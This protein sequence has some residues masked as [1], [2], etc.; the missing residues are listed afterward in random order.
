[1]AGGIGSRFWPYSRNSRPKQFLD[2]FGTGKSLLQMTVDRFLPLIPEKNILVVTNAAYKALVLEQLPA[3]DESQ[4]LC[5][6]C[7]RNT[8]PCIAYATARIQSMLEKQGL[9]E[10]ANIVVAASDHLITDNTAFL[11]T[12]G[13]C[14]DYISDH[15]DIVTLGMLPTRPETGY[16][17]I[18]TDTHGSPLQLNGDGIYKV[19]QFKEKPDL[20]TAKRYIAEGGYLW[21]SGMFIFNLPTI[22]SSFKQHLPAVWHQFEQGKGII[23][24][25]QEPAYINEHFPLCENISIDY[26]IMEKA[27]NVMVMPADFGWSDL[28]TWG[29]LYELSDKDEDGNVVL[30]CK[31]QFDDSRRNIITL[32]SG[33]L[34]VVEGLEDY[35]IAENDRVLLV[36]KKEHEQHIRD[37]VAQA[38]DEFK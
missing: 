14:L 36:C 15:N 13:M 16:G 7:R 31:A 5:E 23:G 9:K 33:K 28:G 37:F 20:E 32:E 26:G 22:V 1:M 30:H 25:A 10:E 3:L 38:D 18:Q 17:Y 2:F 4:V 11:K 21:N 29:S 24:T 6:P 8:A 35:I 12:I 34:A 19:L 27:S